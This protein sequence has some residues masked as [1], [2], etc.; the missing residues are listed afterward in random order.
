MGP[1][2]GGRGPSRP[3]SGPPAFL[4]R[5]APRH[6]GLRPEA[7]AD[8]PA[9]GSPGQ[10]PAP[11]Q[12]LGWDCSVKPSLSS[13]GSH[14]TV[15]GH[16]PPPPRRHAAPG[17]PPP[18]CTSVSGSR[19][20]FSG[21]TPVTCSV[22]APASSPQADLCPRP[23]SAQ[24]RALRPW[25]W[26]RSVW[27]WG[28]AVEPGTAHSPITRWRLW[29]PHCRGSPAGGSRPHVLEQRVRPAGA[30]AWLCLGFRVT[31][32]GALPWGEAFAGST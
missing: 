12:S 28:D 4:P 22:P 19:P 2:G 32:G 3:D 18:P 14:V 17:R 13:S 20:P 21:T 5:S 30:Q 7:A 26:T 29:R 1:P 10:S 31:I 24:G 23:V 27:T 8:S 11:Q 16:T 6:P 25:G 9:P 15:A